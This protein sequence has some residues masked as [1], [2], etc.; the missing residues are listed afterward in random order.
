MYDETIRLCNG[1]R[2]DRRWIIAKVEDIYIAVYQ[3]E[4]PEGYQK[5]DKE[6]AI[7]LGAIIEKNF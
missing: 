6:F 1:Y 4:I 7:E 3:N 2:P 5:G